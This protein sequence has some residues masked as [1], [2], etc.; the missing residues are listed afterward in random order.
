MIRRNQRQRNRF[1]NL[2]LEMNQ[3]KSNKLQLDDLNKNVLVLVRRLIQ[4]KIS[5]KPNKDLY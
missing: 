1:N 4:I 2:C 3:K 5:I